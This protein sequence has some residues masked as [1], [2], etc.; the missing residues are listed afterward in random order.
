MEERGYEA[1]KKKKKARMGAHT[2][3][4]KKKTQKHW[5]R[6]DESETHEAN[7]TVQRVSSAPSMPTERSCWRVGSGRRCSL[8]SLRVSVDVDEC[9]KLVWRVRHWWPAGGV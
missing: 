7:E 2:K 4:Q 1:K 5:R 8:R 9:L 6:A 3:K